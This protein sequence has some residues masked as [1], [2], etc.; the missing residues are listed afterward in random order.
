MTLIERTLSHLA[1]TLEQAEQTE[2]QKIFVIDPR[3]KVVGALLLTIAAVSCARWQI[4]LGLLVSLTVTGRFAGISWSRLLSAWAGGLFFATVVAIPAVFTSGWKLALLL[5]LR[6]EASLTCWL[7][8]MMTTPFNLVLRALRALYVPVVFVAILSMTFRYIF[9]LVRT[10]QDMLLSRRSRIVGRMNAA[11]NRK[12]ASSTAGV[13]LGK[14]L[15]MS[16]DVYHAM[17]SRGFRGEIYIL[18]DF[19][20]AVPD[21]LMLGLLF[22]VAGLILVTGR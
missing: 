11:E 17:A 1:G 2:T 6:S 5:V 18:E 4:I 7:L 21:W 20:M 8:V 14:S 9:L 15:Q 22:S 10:A 19:Q 13:L 12:L 16:D 3:V